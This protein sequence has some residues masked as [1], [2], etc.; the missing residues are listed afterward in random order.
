MAQLKFIL[1]AL[2][3]VS[4]VQ[5]KSKPVKWALT[6]NCSLTVNGST[7]INKFSCVIPEYIKPDT[8]VL[9]TNKDAD[10]VKISGQMILDIKSFDCH[11]GIMTKDL[12]KTLKA[13]QYPKLTVTFISLSK[14]PDPARGASTIS[15]LVNISIAGVSKRFDVA[16]RCT[17]DGPGN[18]TLVGTKTVNFSDFNIIP[19][20]KLGGMIKTNNMLD[21]EFTLKAGILN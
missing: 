8:L 13:E 1:L 15:G 21:V 17:P 9:Y 18:I 3:F 6:K 20:R 11:N 5:D 19:P 7:N 14:Y 12:R 10:G 16:Y 4:A 2:L